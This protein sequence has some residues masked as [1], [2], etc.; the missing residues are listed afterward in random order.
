MGRKVK[1][2]KPDFRGEAFNINSTAFDGYI[3]VQ[4]AAPDAARVVS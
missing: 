1:R 2:F 4:Y 3:A